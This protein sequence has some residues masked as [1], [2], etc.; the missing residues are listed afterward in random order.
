MAI[1]VADDLIRIHIVI[2][3]AIEISIAN[4]LDFFEQGE[5][6]ESKREGFLNYLDSLLGLFHSHHTVEDEQIFPYFQ[7]K[8]LKAPYD[9]MMSQHEALLP[10]L[11]NF[12]KVLNKLKENSDGKGT[13]MSERQHLE[14]LLEILENLQDVWIAHYQLEEEYLNDKN[15]SKL[16]NEQ[17][18]DELS[19]QFGEYAAKHIKKDY[20]VIPFILYNLPPEHRETMK[21]VFPPIVSQKLVPIEWKEKWQSM[22]YFLLV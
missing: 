17:E 18:Q 13:N 21:K 10:L 8:G 1:T 6:E 4:G 11:D 15:I 20:L 5:I 7:N 19:H 16:V 14:F 22:S 3:R 2:T 9:E 12:E